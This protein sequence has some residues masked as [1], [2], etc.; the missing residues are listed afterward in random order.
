MYLVGRGEKAIYWFWEINH[1][2]EYYR[3]FQTIDLARGQE[4]YRDEF[5][6][7]PEEQTDTT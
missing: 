2:L 3:E 1:E 7:W 5:D 6:L 4:V